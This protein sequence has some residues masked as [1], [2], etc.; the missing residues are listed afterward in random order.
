MHVLFDLESGALLLHFHANHDVEVLGFVG[1][2]LIVF[3]FHRETRVISVL[4]VVTCVVCIARRVDAVL[5]K[6]FGASFERVVAAGQVDHGASLPGLIENEERRDA[7]GL[8]HLGIVGTKRGRNVDNARTVFGGDIVAG[9]DTEGALTHFD[10][11][12]ATDAENAVGVRRGVV[13][14]EVGSRVVERFAGLYPRH[15]LGI[16]HTH[17]V[18]ALEVGHYAIGQHLVAGCEGHFGF[19]ALGL[20]VG[21]QAT[22]GQDGGDLLAVVGVE[23]LHC[24]VVDV[25]AD[26]EGGVRGEGPRRGG[27][28]EE[29]RAAPFG[30]C[31]GGVEHFELSGDGRVLHI[32]IGAGLIEFVA[33][34]AGAGSGAVGLNGVT[35]VEVALVI[36]LTKQPPEG[37]DVRIFVRHIGVFHV[38]PVAHEVRKVGP[39]ARKLHDVATT[40]GVV[41][42]DRDFLADVFLGDAE[43]LLHTE[44]YRQTVRIPTGFAL[45]LEALHRFVTAEHVLDGARHHVVNARM[46]VGRGGAFEKHI[47]GT[48]LAL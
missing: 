19:G 47:R 25:R 10:K 26:A 43:F 29:H 41:F 39:F 46:P 7:G 8:G 14:H 38:H 42:L 40:L 37:F 48:T 44:F 35:F 6:G 28:G 15:E 22:F 9:D 30:E 21:S 18:A 27:P 1:S 32:A 2:G 45:H 34:K 24:H 12:I 4:H 36:Q 16:A 17:E 20:E 5:N 13:L 11:T 3:A 23:R 31:R 33:R